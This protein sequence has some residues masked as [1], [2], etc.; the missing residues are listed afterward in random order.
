MSLRGSNGG[1]KMPS[2]RRAAD[3]EAVGPM[4]AREFGLDVVIGR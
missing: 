4:A 2:G 3:L 1:Q